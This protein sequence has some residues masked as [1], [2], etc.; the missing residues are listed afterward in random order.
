MKTEST[1]EA[2]WWD[3]N[4]RIKNYETNL[5]LVSASFSGLMDRR[6]ALVIYY[7]I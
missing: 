1:Y 6:L 5:A 2:Q 7:K 3:K 4:T